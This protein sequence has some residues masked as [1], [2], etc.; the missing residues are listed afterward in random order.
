VEY[1][2]ELGKRGLKPKDVFASLRWNF[3]IGSEFFMELAKFRAARVV[4]SNLVA[5]YGL[6]PASFSPRIAAR[7]GLIDKTIFDPHNNILRNSTQSFAAILG[8]VESLHIGAFDEVYRTP[9]IFSRRIAENVHLI[10]REEMG[11]DKLIDP[12]GGSYAVESLTAELAGK[13]W[14]K[15][16]CI[17]KSGGY[18]KAIS[19]GDLQRSIGETAAERAKRFRQRRDVLIGTNRYAVPNEIVPSATVE[20]WE[21]LRQRR[22]D[23]I[24]ALRAAQSPRRTNALL[25]LE[26]LATSSRGNKRVAA[27]AVEAAAASCTI[28]ELTKALRSA[29]LTGPAKISPLRCGRL[30]LP[31]ETIR[32]QSQRTHAKVLLLCVGTPKQYKVRTDWIREFCE[33]GGIEVEAAIIDS[34]DK[35]GA[36]LTEHSAHAAVICSDD[37]SYPE[38]VP[39]LLRSVG[40]NPPKIYLAGAIPEPLAAD[41]LAAGLSGSIHIKSNHLQVVEEILNLYK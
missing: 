26:R 22:A 9:D 36:T 21:S 25:N 20:D 11:L 28:S 15:F 38:V 5:A 31:Y 41:W 4:W 10:L 17:E 23:E 18:R 37:E 29:T 13:A 12:A 6:K 40:T 24:R 34:P 8:G 3:H 39:A 7:T 16:Q 30:A 35:A 1:I 2:R 19:D 33:A 32:G 14:E 27:A